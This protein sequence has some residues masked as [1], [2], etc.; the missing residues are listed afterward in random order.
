MLDEPNSNLD[1]MGELALINS[2]RR[3]Q[4]RGAIVLVVAHR[5][6]VL[7]ATTDLMVLDA[8]KIRDFGP[9]DQV[10]Q[11]L[12]AANTAAPSKVSANV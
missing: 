3:Q 9:R 7:E 2:I 11:R 12:A 5:R 1:A 10:L 8:G 4:Q 6:H